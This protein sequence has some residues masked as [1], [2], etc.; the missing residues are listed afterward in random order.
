MATYYRTG[1]GSHRHA[2]WSC[3]N[4]HRSVFT[5]DPFAIP[6]SEVDQWAPC[7]TCCDA[8]VV[9]ESAK[10]VASAADDMC[11]N[12]GVTNPR[13]LRSTC[14]DCGKEGAVNAKTGRLRAHKRAS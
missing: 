4:S 13:R 9:A 7:T 6:A 12:G 5:G 8:D 11:R 10:V 1:K 3:A 14:V 2:S